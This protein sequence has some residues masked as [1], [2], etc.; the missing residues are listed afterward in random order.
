MNPTTYGLDLAKNVFQV[1]WIEC[2]GR[3]RNVQIKR[4]KLREFFTKRVPG[5]VAMESCATAHYWGRELAALGH[6]VL[7]IHA[8][9]VKAYV[10]GAHK[11]DAHDAV[12]IWRA[13]ND[14]M[15]RAVTIKTAAQQ[16]VL[17]LHRI[18]EQLVKMRT[19]QINQMR[20]LLLEFGI[21]LSTGR[22]AGMKSFA[23]QAEQIASVLGG[24]LTESLREQFARIGELDGHI[25][26]QE[27]RIADQARTDPRCKRLEKVSG[28][29]PLTASAAVATLGDA[30][31][32]AS[33]RELAAFLGLVP[34]QT[35]TGGKTRLGPI[36]R[37]GDEYLRRLFIH[38]AR[39]VVCRGK[40]HS[41][42]LAQAIARRPKNVAVVAQAN[43]MVRIA[44][45]LLAHER[46]Y[47]PKHVSQR[48]ARQR[49]AAAIA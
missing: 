12:A 42:W 36:T 21:V 38:G 49:P 15:T 22:E 26:T 39:A 19:M 33:G 8:R 20:G 44:W 25:A 14:P 3:E 28:I 13:A 45:A 47:D 16:S 6:E 23:T 46:E 29:G 24:P 30:R 11:S 27:R 7:A 43:K 5:R 10:V 17:A 2:D 34:R 32:F 18:R 48:P 40:D 9:Y 31:A 35:G 4:A 37:G 41:P 1:F